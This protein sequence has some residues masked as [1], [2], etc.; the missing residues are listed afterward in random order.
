MKYCCEPQNALC[1]G[2][3]QGHFPYFF[4][5]KL[6]PVVAAGKHTGRL[7]ARSLVCYLVVR[8]VGMSATTVAKRVNLSQLALS[9]AVARGERLAADLGVVSRSFSLRSRLISAS[10]DNK[11]KSPPCGGDFDGICGPQGGGS[12]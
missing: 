3:N 7:Q 5:G 11:T 10:G 8:Q 12:G 9:R 2:K 4:E 1:N 6:D